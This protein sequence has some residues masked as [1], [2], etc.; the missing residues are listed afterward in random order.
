ME[1][2]AP[3]V[4]LR[5][6]VMTKLKR[7]LIAPSAYK[8]TLSAV[9]LADAI[10]AGITSTS[11]AVEL[12]RRPIADGGDGTL[13]AIAAC[14]GG[15]WHALRVPDAIGNE[16][17]ASWLSVGKIAIVEL[18][19]SCGLGLLSA[20]RLQ[21]LAA[22]TCAVGLL[23]QD[24]VDQN[25]STI[26]VCVGGSAS[27]D[28][29]SGALTA[30]GARFYDRHGAQLRNG[31]G[32]LVDLESCD[33]HALSKLREITIRVATDVTNPL[34][35]ANGAARVYGP[36]KGAD[37]QEVELLERGLKR[38][39]DVLEE[40]V[41]NG[42]REEPGTG[43]AGGIAFGLRCALNAQI[44]PGFSWLSEIMQLDEEIASC[45]VVI[46]AE[47]CLDE[48]S[49]AGKAT[50]ELAK[51][52]RAYGKPLLAVPAALSPNLDWRLHGISHAVATAAPNRTADESD[53]AAAA[54]E[55]FAR[56]FS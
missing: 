10:A 32:A 5:V 39:A 11:A 25:F 38:F 50:G 2:S 13:D 41:G 26:I 3:L 33:L 49:L 53:V 46:T 40:S 12:R 27:T 21:P 9:V 52:C 37:E 19:N 24:C 17:V 36:Q 51:K 34:L 45:D 48:Q 44:I 20:E 43:A 14:V 6:G 22:A 28:G 54:K 1:E 56:V 30:L 18:A 55:L 7:I 29:G 4:I 23:I 35:G 15:G 8:G 31:G 16:H 42:V 47:G